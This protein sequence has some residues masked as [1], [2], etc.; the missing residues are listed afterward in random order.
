[1]NHLCAANKQ[2]DGTTEGA[3]WTATN[4]FQAHRNSEKERVTIERIERFR[5]RVVKIHLRL[6]IQATRFLFFSVGILVAVHRFSFLSIFRVPIAVLSLWRVRICG[7]KCVASCD[8]QITFYFKMWNLHWYQNGGT[9][10]ASAFTPTEARANGI[11]KNQS[12]THGKRTPNRLAASNT[13]RDISRH[14]N[15]WVLETHKFRMHTAHGMLPHI[16]Y[17]AN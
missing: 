12:R 15:W 3:Q 4:T 10:S 16:Q 1:M 14:R 13:G 8:Q 6:K 7:W 17:M 5:R 9:V 2:W 11:L